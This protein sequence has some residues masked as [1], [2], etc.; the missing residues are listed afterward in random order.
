MASLPDWMIVANSLESS[1]KQN[2][3]GQVFYDLAKKYDPKLAVEIG[4][5]QGYSAIWTMAGMSHG[6]FWFGYDLF[7]DYYYRHCSMDTAWDNI[8]RAG[9]ASKASLME[10]GYMGAIGNIKQV[11][12]E[13]KVEML[14]VDIS[15]DG[16][17]IQFSAEA[18]Y[19]L[20]APKG[21]LIFEGGSK[22][23]DEVEWMGKYKKPKIFPAISRVLA[24]GRYE[25]YDFFSEFPSITV[26]RRI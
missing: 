13:N 16:D 12:G 2:N 5:Y 24:E 25:L 15:N 18:F 3:L 9:V 6:S 17:V 20:L 21:L 11:L 8:C 10:I 26:L 4:V 22:E 7:D 23:R 19:N 14:H 1:Y